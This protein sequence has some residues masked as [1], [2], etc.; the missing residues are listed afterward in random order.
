ML[1][2]HQI[3]IYS[4]EIIYYSEEIVN[5]FFT[6]SPYRDFRINLFALSIAMLSNEAR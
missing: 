6:K 4:E 1:L 3:T 2:L 5:I